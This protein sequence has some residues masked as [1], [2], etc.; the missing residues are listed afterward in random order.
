MDAIQP[1]SALFR[2]QFQCELTFLERRSKRVELVS[3][4][5]IYHS[6]ANSTKI[7]ED[8]GYFITET[9]GVYTIMSGESLYLST[10]GELNWGLKIYVKHRHGNIEVEFHGVKMRFN[11]PLEVFHALL[12]VRAIRV[13]LRSP[14]EIRNVR[15][16]E[17]HKIGVINIKKFKKQLSLGT[18]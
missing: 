16:I 3:D 5:I 1:F 13:R 2:D 18:R 6:D 17:H 14:T 4:G 8:N 11:A 15:M 9:D 10:L 12:A 7:I